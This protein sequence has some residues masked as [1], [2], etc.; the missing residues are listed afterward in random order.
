ME[1]NKCRK[2]FKILLYILIFLYES[3]YVVMFALGEASVRDL[4]LASIFCT[5]MTLSLK[6]SK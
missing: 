5:L 6:L 2:N 3:V 4:L 1:T